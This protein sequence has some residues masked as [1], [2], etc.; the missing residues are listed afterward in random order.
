MSFECTAKFSSGSNSLL[1]ILFEIGKRAISVAKIQANDELFVLKA[2]FTVALL[3]C[4]NTSL[5]TMDVI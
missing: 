2:A 4:I 1:Y 5:K 3:L